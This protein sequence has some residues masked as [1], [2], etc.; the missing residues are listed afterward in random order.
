MNND[1]EKKRRTYSLN[2]DRAMELAH[3]S[4]AMSDELGK[5]VN[6]QGVLDVLVHLLN[7]DLI[8]RKKVVA[9]LKKQ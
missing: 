2:G 7:T 1:K 8:V 6:R 9:I 3:Q 4:L 5:T